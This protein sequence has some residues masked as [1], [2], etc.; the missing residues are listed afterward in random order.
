ME[1]TAVPAFKD[2]KAPSPCHV[3]GPAASDAVPTETDRDRNGAVPMET[4]VPV[5]RFHSADRSHFGE[6]GNT[7]SPPCPLLRR[8]TAAVPVEAPVDDLA[9][10][11]PSSSGRKP[12]VG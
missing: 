9:G 7:A 6:T 5:D 4:D 12:E 1:A 3:G 11:V 8:A 10:L 2:L